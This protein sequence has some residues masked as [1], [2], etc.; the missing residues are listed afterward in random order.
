MGDIDFKKELKQFYA[1]SSKAP[2]IVNVPDQN[3][4]MIDGMGDPN[5]APS[6]MEAMQALYT[7]SYTIKFMVKRGPL[8][9]DFSVMPSE[10][11]WWMDDMSL[12]SMDNKDKWKW[13][14]MIMQ[15]AAYVTRALYDQAV[16]QVAGK[17]KLPALQ[18]LRFEN[19]HEGLCAQILRMGPYSTEGPTIKMLHNFIEENGYK[20]RG[21]HHEIYFNDPDRTAPEKLKTILRQPIE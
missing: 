5:T 18:K 1:A 17:K 16:D 12:F 19:F 7:V 14:M 6:Y 21:K 11:L 2:S 20:L 9:V 8:A 3:F 15:P 4:V 13:T 10:G